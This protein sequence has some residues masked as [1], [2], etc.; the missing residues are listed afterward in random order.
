MHL[1]QL[2]SPFLKDHLTQLFGNLN[3]TETKADCLNCICAQKKSETLPLYRADI[4]CCTFRPFIPNFAVGAILDQ[5]IL[6]LSNYPTWT[7]VNA[8]TKTLIENKIKKNEYTLPLGIFAPVR[9]QYHFHRRKPEDFGNNESMV[10]PYMMRDTAQCGLWIHRSSVCMSYYCASDYGK[11]G[12]LFWELFGDYV[13]HLEMAL[14]QDCMVSM[15]FSPDAIDLQLEY[16]SCETATPE[17]LKTDSMPDA[18]SNSYWQDWG[19][20]DYQE[21][22]RACARYAHDLKPQLINDM[23]DEEGFHMQDELKTII[24]QLNLNK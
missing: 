8:K 24:T 14:A 9:Y 19:N 5:S 13:H 6:D 23:I 21:Y 3:L 17:E 2:V 10:C 16:M 1:S 11:N 12:L 18:L 15:G 7:V 20:Q 4:K 22:Y